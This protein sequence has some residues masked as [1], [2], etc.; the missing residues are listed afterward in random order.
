MLLIAHPLIN[1]FNSTEGK[2]IFFL[3]GRFLKENGLHDDHPQY[4]KFEYAAMIQ[5]LA[6]ADFHIVSEIGPA[7]TNAIDYAIKIV[8]QIDSLLKIGVSSSAIMVTGTS[9]GAYI[10]QYVSTFAKNSQ[11]NFVFIGCYRDSDLK[12][13]PEI[14]LCGNILNIY[15]RSDSFG[16][17]ALKRRE[18]STMDIPMFKELELNTGRKHGFCTRL[19]RDGSNH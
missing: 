8:D 6:A 9:K 15:E 16:V 1:R 17:S 14:N 7:G 18:H 2:Y 12:E 3:H 5:A 13:I 19:I 10:A 11:L 4:G